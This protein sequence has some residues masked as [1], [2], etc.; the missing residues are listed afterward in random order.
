MND[1]IGALDDCQPLGKETIKSD[2]KV[3]VIVKEFDEADIKEKDG[4]QA[5]DE[6]GFNF[7]DNTVFEFF[8]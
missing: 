5:I 1:S 8:D 6:G 3:E 7:K 2:E 4:K